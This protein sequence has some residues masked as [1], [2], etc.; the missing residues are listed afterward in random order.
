MSPI[1]KA[2]DPS[3]KELKNHCI[4][5]VFNP[6]SNLLYFLFFLFFWLSFAS[7]KSFGIVKSQAVERLYSRT[8]VCYCRFGTVF[9]H[10]VTLYRFKNVFKSIPGHIKSIPAHIVSWL[11]KTILMRKHWPS[12]LRWISV[13]RNWEIRNMVL[14]STFLLLLT[15]FLFWISL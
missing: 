4:M 3:P 9:I 1:F 2:P 15:R 12:G 7:S 8:L 14:L 6:I 11:G 10:I 5:L 13:V